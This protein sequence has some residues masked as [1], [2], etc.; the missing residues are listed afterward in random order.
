VQGLLF[1][2]IVTSRDLL[3]SQANY[4]Q[5]NREAKQSI[6]LVNRGQVTSILENRGFAKTFDELGI[7]VLVGGKTANSS[8]FQYKIDLKSRDLAIIGAKPK[9]SDRRGMNGAVLRSKDKKGILAIGRIICQSNTLGADGTAAI[10]L[11]IVDATGKLSCA[12]N[13]K[14]LEEYNNNEESTDREQ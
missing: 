9:D 11:P 1:V 2:S 13:W 14:V 6:L 8:Q 10:N 5:N 3:S 4:E 12:P 7:G